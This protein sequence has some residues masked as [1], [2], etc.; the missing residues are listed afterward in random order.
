MDLQRERQQV[1]QDIASL[2]LELKAAQA[3]AER[4]SASGNAVEMARLDDKEK[5]LRAKELELLS[6]ENKLLTLEA[7]RAGTRL[8]AR[9]CSV[10]SSLTR[11]RDPLQRKVKAA[12]M[13][14]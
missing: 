13:R 11:P 1:A 10:H 4:A 6:K 9:C 14:T 12:R 5:Y 8:A 7:V 2:Q 3:A